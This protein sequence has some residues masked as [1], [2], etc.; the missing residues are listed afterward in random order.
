MECN[1]GPE[2][3]L[4]FNGPGAKPGE[5]DEVGG[6]LAH[7]GANILYEGMWA[8]W[9][10]RRRNCGTAESGLVSSRSTPSCD[11]AL[12]AQACWM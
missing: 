6:I 7:T 2:R 9:A 3:L 4:G 11:S 5:T 12:V 1:I 8:N 10:R